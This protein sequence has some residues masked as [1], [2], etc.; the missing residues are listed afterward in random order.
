MSKRLAPSIGSVY[1]SWTVV[2]E[3]ETKIYSNGKIK[4]MVPV[5]CKCGLVKNVEQWSLQSGGSKSCA[6]C[7]KSKQRGHS[8]LVGNRFGDWIVIGE[9]E[10]ELYPSG[11]KRWLVPV[12]CKCG[13]I[14]KVD[15]YA[16]TAGNTSS[17]QKCMGK[18]FRVNHVSVGDKI[19]NWTVIGESRTKPSGSGEPRRVALVQC[20]CGNKSKM[21]VSRLL[22]GKRF[23][24]RECSDKA[25]RLN[26]KCHM[27]EYSI[28]R[29]MLA[30]C[31][32]E[33]HVSYDKYGGAGV[34][35]CDRWNP[36]RGGSFNNFYE[37]VGP[38]PSKDH[39]LDKE[40]VFLGNKVY[41]PGLAKWVTRKDNCRRR[42][43]TFFVQFNGESISLADLADKFKVQRH[44]LYFQIKYMSLSPEESVKR[45][46][47]GE[48][49]KRLLIDRDLKLAATKSFTSADQNI[50]A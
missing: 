29:N 45:V 1:G 3:R 23:A 40:A 39:Q 15:P 16:L 26:A 19:N 42:S 17:C 28:W 13:A 18:K 36:A 6:R 49:L 4:Y 24:C 21:E 12:K 32:K 37:D 20:K 35:V 30:R 31:Y 33:N 10:F 44:S 41:G 22:S 9:K 38:R 27:G 48:K 34:V 14:K 25:K 46:I 5:K 50:N 11:K 8:I 43:N 2:G 47:E 7:S